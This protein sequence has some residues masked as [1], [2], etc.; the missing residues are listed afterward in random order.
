MKCPGCGSEGPFEIEGQAWF[1]VSDDGSSDFK[2]LRWEA[3]SK[4]HCPLCS[5]H[6]EVKDTRK[7]TAEEVVEHLWR[8]LYVEDDGTINPDKEWP[9]ADAMD[10]IAWTVHQFK[11]APEEVAS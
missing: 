4:I 8:L 11:P 5:W 7:W 3:N 9:G 6:G 10:E 1:E 2:D